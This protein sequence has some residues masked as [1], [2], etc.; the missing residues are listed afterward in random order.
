MRSRD[1]RIRDARTSRIRLLAIPSLRS[2]QISPIPPDPSN[3]TCACNGTTR[4]SISLF[5]LLRLWAIPI[6]VEQ[7][8]SVLQHCSN[9]LLVDCI[10]QRKTVGVA[11]GYDC[12]TYSDLNS[13]TGSICNTSQIFNIAFRLIL[14]F[15][16]S[17]L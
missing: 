15:P 10:S 6:F 4:Y 5:P 2:L 7:T 17:T 13:S 16:L 3:C 11:D 1:Y 12:Y 9:R 14:I 8:H